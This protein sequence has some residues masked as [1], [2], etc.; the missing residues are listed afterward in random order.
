M[1]VVVFQPLFGD[2]I[3]S[4][5]HSERGR[6][7]S[8][9]EAELFTEMPPASML[10]KALAGVTD[11]AYVQCVTLQDICP[12]MPPSFSWRFLPLE[13]IS[14]HSSRPAP[15]SQ[16]ESELVD[17]VFRDYRMRPF[18]HVTCDLPTLR[19]E[20]RRLENTPS[21]LKIGETTDVIQSMVGMTAVNAYHPQM[22]SVRCR[23]FMTPLEVFEDDVLFKEAI[24]KRIRYGSNLK[25]WGIRKSLFSMRR[26]QRVSNFRPSAAKAIYDHFQPRLALDFSMGWGGRMLGAFSSGTPYVGIDPNTSTIRNNRRLAEDLKSVGDLPPYEI[27]EACAE[28]ILGTGRWNPDLIFTS[29]PYFDVE[30]YSD[31]PTQS[32]MRYPT[33]EGWYSGFLKPCIEGSFRDLQRRGHLVL[34]V[35]KDMEARTRELAITAGFEYLDTWNLLLSQHQYNKASCGLYRKEPILVFRKA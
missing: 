17:R 19:S 15:G 4:F 32:Y 3:I 5:Y 6:V 2:G 31:E 25:D 22:V 7:A 14:F 1:Y 8:F 27:V 18:P 20:F 28:D 34:N 9:D 24:R 13:E 10:N 26:T 33:E 12:I 30:K 11:L 16:E 21:C 29:P 35:N 23:N